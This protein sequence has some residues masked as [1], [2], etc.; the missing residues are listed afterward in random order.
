M[1]AKGRDAPAAVRY[2][3]GRLVQERWSP[4][5]GADGEG[6]RRDLAQVVLDRAR[7]DEQPGGDLGVGQAIPGQPGDLG[8]LRG[9]RAVRLGGAPRAVSPVARTLAGA[10]VIPVARRLA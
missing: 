3:S 1:K 9:E 2:A 5:T 4:R 6:E 7:A 10:T 8:L